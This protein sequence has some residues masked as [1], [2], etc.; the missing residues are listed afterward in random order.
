MIIWVLVFGMSLTLSGSGRLDMG[1]QVEAVFKSEKDCLEVKAKLDQ[2][3]KEAV[4]KG[5]V[6]PQINSFGAVCVPVTLNIHNKRPTKG[7]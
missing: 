7:A 3:S 5:Q 4:E 6:E 2:G 1:A